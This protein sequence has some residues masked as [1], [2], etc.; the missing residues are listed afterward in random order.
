MFQV[1]I[2]LQGSEWPCCYLQIT[3]LCK[4]A[5]SGAICQ[6]PQGRG[7]QKATDRSKPLKNV[8]VFVKDLAS[9]VAETEY[10]SCIRR[11]G[12]SGEIV[13]IKGLRRSLPS[14]GS[15]QEF[16][17]DLQKGG[18]YD[19]SSFASRGNPCH[20]KK[21]KRKAAVSRL[22]ICCSHSSSTSVYHIQAGFFVQQ[23]HNKLIDAC[24][25]KKLSG[26]GR[27]S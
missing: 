23:E 1:P 5:L 22:R 11:I 7:K 27:L 24:K 13:N 20:W 9:A 21:R 10:H 3:A 8:M 26:S 14:E 16:V 12:S 15:W 17:Y 25:K 18:I 4:A 2:P 6:R 19:G